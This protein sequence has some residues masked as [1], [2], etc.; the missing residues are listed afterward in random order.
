LS[1]PRWTIRTLLAAATAAGALGTGCSDRL[2]APE[3]MEL[4]D[5]LE[6]AVSPQAEERRQHVLEGIIWGW[7]DKL[8]RIPSISQVHLRRD[9]RLASYRALVFERVMVPP[10]GIEDRSGCAGTRWFAVLWRE[11]EEPGVIGMSGGQF[12]GPWVHGFHSCPDVYFSRPEP[13]L[14]FSPGQ[15]APA[16]STLW[17][18][19]GE[20][21]ISPGEVTGE[22]GFLASEDTRL[23]QERYGI[24]CAM[25]RH[26]VRF[27][28]RLV[29]A[30][31]SE[32]SVLDLEPTEVV[33]FRYT[34]QCDSIAH[35][36]ANE[37]YCAGRV[38]PGKSARTIA[39]IRS[40]SDLD[41]FYYPRQPIYLGQ[42]QLVGIWLTPHA[43]PIVL[44][45]SRNLEP[46]WFNCREQDV[47]LDTLHLSCEDY[48]PSKRTIRVDGSF[49]LK[50]LA[51]STVN[52]RDVDVLSAVV[53]VTNKGRPEYSRR[54][55]FAFR[56]H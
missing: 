5:S 39:G 45:A 33:G 19:E 17:A 27:R 41:G 7:G 8:A 2:T 23:L 50:G 44:Q 11:G 15:R 38:V 6:A 26:R 32:T 29:G 12:R 53:S 56:P 3:A 48:D 52:E 47:S 1:R 42:D 14:Y 21:D 9:G 4:V 49:L 25:T 28:V 18:T 31:S 55:R 51:E 36:E 37:P 24:T 16:Q 30:G 40:V 35:P 43:S 22:C 34:I 13:S 20:G 10:G 54:H 46:E